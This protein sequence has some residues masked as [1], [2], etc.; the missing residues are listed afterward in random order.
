MENNN[1]KRATSCILE[2]QSYPDF[3]AIDQA[4]TKL[5]IS[6]VDSRKKLREKHFSFSAFTIHQ[7]RKYWY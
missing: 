3:D 2:Y 7:R 1:I 6:T 4:S 5:L